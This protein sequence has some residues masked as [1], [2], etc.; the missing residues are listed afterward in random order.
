MLEVYYILAKI[1]QFFVP[2]ILALEIEIF[3]YSELLYIF[4][5][6]AKRN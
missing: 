2:I 5:S 3:S 1:K 4:P 6:T